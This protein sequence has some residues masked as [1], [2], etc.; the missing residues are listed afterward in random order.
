MMVPVEQRVALVAAAAM[1]SIDCDMQR[2]ETTEKHTPVRWRIIGGDNGKGRKVQPR[3]QP[4]E[5]GSGL[6]AKRCCVYF[7]L[8][9]E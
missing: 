6:K 5:C 8:E 3:N 7:K 2:Y 9:G 1:L 4:C